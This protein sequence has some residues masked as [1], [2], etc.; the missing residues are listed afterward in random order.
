VQ[1]ERGVGG[2]EMMTRGA[3]DRFS[4][5]FYLCGGAR[6]RSLSVGIYQSVDGFLIGAYF[7]Y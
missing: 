6:G 1:V 5:R 3:G 7:L 2:G 4:I